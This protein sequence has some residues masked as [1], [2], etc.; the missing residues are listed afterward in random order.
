MMVGETYN[1]YSAWRPMSVYINGQYWGLYELREKF[2]T[3]YFKEQDT[4]TVSTVDILSQ[5]Y[6]YQNVLRSVSGNP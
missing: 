1:Y 3:E 6:F 5:S 2:D 4:A